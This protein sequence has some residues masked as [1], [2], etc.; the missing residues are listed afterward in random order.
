[1]KNKY[2]LVLIIF[3]ILIVLSFASGSVN[4]AVG[5]SSSE[6]IAARIPES[7]EF[8]T[9]V[10][11]DP[12][13]M[14]QFSDISQYLNESGQRDI[15]RNPTVSNGIFSGTTVGDIK[16]GTNGNF[17][18]LFPGYETAMLIGKVGHRYPIDA[19]LYQCLYIAMKVDSPNVGFVPDHFRV[20]WFADE[21][22]NKAVYGS[23]DAI[24][25][26][27]PDSAPPLGVHIWK[28]HKVD[29]S[30]TTAGLAAWNDRA[31]WQGLRIDPTFNANTSFAVD[32]VRLTKC[33]SNLHTI[34]WNPNSSLT[35]MW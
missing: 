23:S 30:T 14:E 10:L 35:T 2:L 27:E 24:R 33:Q 7:D 20:L 32:W 29:L 5:T 4:Q 26:F 28:L 12:W 18:P 3:T 21:R 8:A 25:L 17:F 19:N 13:D 16:A 15:I 6:V 31:F 11:R 22:L 9:L 34:T 1:V